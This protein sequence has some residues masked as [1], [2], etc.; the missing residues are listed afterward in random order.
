MSA[1]PTTALFASAPIVRLFGLELARCE[2]EL[3]EVRMPARAELGQEVGRVQGGALGVLADH[4][5]V[6]LLIPHLGDGESVTSV[7]FKLNFLRAA[8]PG[9]E[10]LVA[11]A[12]PI[13][14]G[15][16]TALCAVDIHQGERHVAHGL[17]TY[18]RL[19]AT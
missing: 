7:E 19:P 17:F 10:Q 9:G 16:T 14:R 6:Y 1:D 15:R 8:Q 13:H 12:T 5:A 11:R 18:L 4:A 2:P 3:V